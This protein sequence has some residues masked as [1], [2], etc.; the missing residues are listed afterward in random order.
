MLKNSQ[1]KKNKKTYFR[2]CLNE[3]YFI[4]FRQKLSK[5]ETLEQLQNDLSAAEATLTTDEA[6]LAQAQSAVDADNATIT[7][8]NAKIAIYNLVPALEALTADEVVALNALLAG[9]PN[10][11]S[12]TI[13]STNTGGAEPDNAGS[14][15]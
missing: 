14:G 11:V 2:Y 9:S 3:I 1:S 15:Q 6:T 5:M 7:S 10:G 4:I 13:A 8:I 12:I